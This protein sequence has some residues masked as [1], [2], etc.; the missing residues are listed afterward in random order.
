MWTTSSNSIKK[1]KKKADDLYLC[2]MFKKA[3]IFSINFMAK[4]FSSCIIVAFVP[5]VLSSVCVSY[6]GTS[7]R[8]VL[9]FA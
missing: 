2:I 9:Y 8:D 5:T 7:L 4:T 6:S 3:L 1:K